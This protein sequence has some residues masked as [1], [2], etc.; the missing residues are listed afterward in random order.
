M[1]SPRAWALLARMVLWRVSLPVLTRVLPLERLVGLL[2]RPRE[3]RREA[4]QEL[5]QRAAHRLWRDAEGPCLQ[6]SLALYRELGRLGGEP[7]LVCGV[8]RSGGAVVGHAW[9]EAGGGVAVDA[10]GAADGYERIVAYSPT[11]AR[12]P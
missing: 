11:G 12:E 4:E 2:A 7:R 9:V 6:R 8:S 10:P 5:A 3:R 1:R